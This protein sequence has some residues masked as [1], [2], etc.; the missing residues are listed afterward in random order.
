MNRV[1]AAAPPVAARIDPETFEAERDRLQGWMSEAAAAG[2]T[3]LALSLDGVEAGNSLL[4]ALLLA[5]V[6]HAQTL[7]VGLEFWSVPDAVREIADFSGLT[8]LLPLTEAAREPESI[9][10]PSGPSRSSHD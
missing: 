6:R 5:L 1:V 3:P 8:G 9:T 4:I 2:Q 10:G 7:G